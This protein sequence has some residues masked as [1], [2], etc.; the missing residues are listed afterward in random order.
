LP[1]SGGIANA[2]SLAR[3][4]AALGAGGALDGV[5][6]LRPGSIAAAVVPHTALVDG[7]REEVNFALGYRV[8]GTYFSY[9]SLLRALSTRSTVFGHSGAGGTMAFADPVR[10]FAFAMTKNLLR[11]PESGVEFPTVGIVRLV[12]AALGVAD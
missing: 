10:R 5:R 7:Q 11:H 3:M 9:P 4:Y 8:G 6:L 12:R 2:R 1:S